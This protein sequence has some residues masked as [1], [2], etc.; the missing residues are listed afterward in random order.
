[1]EMY[2][3]TLNIVLKDTEMCTVLLYSKGFTGKARHSLG[4]THHVPSLVTVVPTHEPAV[5]NDCRAA[6]IPTSG[7]AACLL[8]RAP[9]T[10]HLHTRPVPPHL[11]IVQD[12]APLRRSH[13]QP[14]TD[15]KSVV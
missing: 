7:K 4:D 5:P 3:F 9:S 8:G 15:R 14:R 1:M 11:Y 2:K 13:V 12:S 6:A 10:L